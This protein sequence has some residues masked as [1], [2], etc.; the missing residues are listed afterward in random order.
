M[1][2]SEKRRHQVDLGRRRP[3]TFRR[4]TP[5]G[6]VRGRPCLQVSRK[7][8]L[9]EKERP[10][11]AGR[12][13]FTLFP[14]YSLAF[15]SSFACRSEREPPKLQTAAQHVV[16]CADEPA[17]LGVV[18]RPGEACIHIF[19]P[20]R[21]EVGGQA[22]V[23]THGRGPGAHKTPGEGVLVVVGQCR[24]AGPSRVEGSV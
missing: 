3:F 18:E 22:A 23:I 15:F 1:I 17:T 20:Q 4:R 7:N 9:K 10:S 13:F 16:I 6:R 8:L 21:V 5:S 24:P 2:S 12:S 14:S 19:R 11:E